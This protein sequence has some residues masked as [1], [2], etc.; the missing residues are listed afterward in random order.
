MRDTAGGNT[1]N[2]RAICAAVFGPDMTASA[3]SRRL[4][5]GAHPPVDLAQQTPSRKLVDRT[6]CPHR[7]PDLPH[8]SLTFA[9][10]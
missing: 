2:I 3:I 7:V 6:A 10:C 9:S 4:V 5:Q 1:P 8:V